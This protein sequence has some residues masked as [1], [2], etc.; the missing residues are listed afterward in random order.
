MESPKTFKP[1]EMC[2]CILCGKWII[3]KSG[4]KHLHNLHEKYMMGI[5]DPIYDELFV[6]CSSELQKITKINTF[7]GNQKMKIKGQPRGPCLEVRYALKTQYLSKK[8]ATQAVT[9]EIRHL[10]SDPNSKDM[11]QK[12][13]KRSKQGPKMKK[14]VHALEQTYEQTKPDACMTCFDEISEDADYFTFFKEVGGAVTLCNTVEYHS[15]CSN[16]HNMGVDSGMKLNSCPKCR[17]EGFF[18]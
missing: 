1:D 13:M 14:Y 7:Y 11:L 3:R 6:E 12:F 15:I 5:E 4:P 9:T 18:L 10:I 8:T 17:C 2:E 16:C